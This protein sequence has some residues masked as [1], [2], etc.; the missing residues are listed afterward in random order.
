MAKTKK[1]SKTDR[2]IPIINEWLLELAADGHGVKHAGVTK[3][4]RAIVTF[5]NDDTTK[6]DVYALLDELDNMG[7]GWEHYGIEYPTEYK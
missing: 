2:I 4:A 1:L 6:E 3:L 5:V 7:P